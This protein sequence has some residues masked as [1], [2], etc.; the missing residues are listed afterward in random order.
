MEIQLKI[1]LITLI[2]LCLLFVVKA[3]PASHGGE[4]IYGVI[5]P[6]CWDQLVVLKNF[7]MECLK[8]VFSKLLGYSIVFAS[9]IVKVPQ[10]INIVRAGSTEGLTELVLYMESIGY[11]LGVLYPMH[12]GQPF[13]TY[14]ESLFI[15]I[16]AII[17]MCLLW[18]YNGNKYRLPFII[19]ISGAYIAYIYILYNGTLLDDRAWTLL[20]SVIP[21]MSK[22]RK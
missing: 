15:A 12:Y 11:V 17:I 18:Y 6:Y 2:L 8:F 7:D 9:S 10:V 4:L 14:G 3:G 13:S 1:L 19:L 20:Y 22:V 16:Q 21:Q 5:S